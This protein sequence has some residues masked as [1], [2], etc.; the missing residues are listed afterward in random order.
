MLVVFWR[1]HSITS[2]LYLGRVFDVEVDIRDSASF[3]ILNEIN[4]N[5][6]KEFA[7]NDRIRQV[8]SL[9]AIVSA[10]LINFKIVSNFPYF[11]FV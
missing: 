4:E 6:I 8:S 2:S 9:S 11:R 3:R 10:I 1:D 7:I 5:S